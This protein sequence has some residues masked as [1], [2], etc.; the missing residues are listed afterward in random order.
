MSASFALLIYYAEIDKVTALIYFTLAMGSMG[1]YYTGAQANFLD[2]CP[3]YSGAL[4]GLVNST[5]GICAFLVPF[6]TNKLTTKVILSS[7]VRI[8]F[9]I[10]S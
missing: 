1:A 10:D 7:F 2:I 4:T 6:M 9:A 5:G 3:N 8:V